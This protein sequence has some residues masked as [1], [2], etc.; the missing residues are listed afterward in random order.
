VMFGASLW[1]DAIADWA[2]M[3]ELIR[4]NANVLVVRFIVVPIVIKDCRIN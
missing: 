2:M 4:L 3:T 1:L